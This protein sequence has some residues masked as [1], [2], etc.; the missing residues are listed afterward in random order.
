MELSNID[1]NNSKFNQVNKIMSSKDSSTTFHSQLV[2][3]FNFQAGSIQ[4]AQQ[5]H[6]QT[7]LKAQSVKNNI[8]FTDDADDDEIMDIIKELK[9]LILEL[10]KFEKKHNRL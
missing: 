8:R 1:M 2:S 6:K 7:L 9:C 3:K 5:M 4:A 10:R